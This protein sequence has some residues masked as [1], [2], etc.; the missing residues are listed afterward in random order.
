M[1]EGWEGVECWG[2]T[3]GIDLAAEFARTICDLEAVHL[4]RPDPHVWVLEGVDLGA[5]K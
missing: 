2:V 4:D 1:G 3:A 5:G